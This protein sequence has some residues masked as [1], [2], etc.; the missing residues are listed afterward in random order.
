MPS[1]EVVK[2]LRYA[3]GILSIGLGVLVFAGVLLQDPVPP[4]IR[5]T[6]GTVLVLLGL[7]R[8]LTTLMRTSRSHD[9]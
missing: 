9:A 7:Y 8:L 1:H 5:Y 6:F 4:Q 2:I 3:L